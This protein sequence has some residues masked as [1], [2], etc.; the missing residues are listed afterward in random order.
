MVH[1][2]IEPGPHHLGL[3]RVNIR[4]G[5]KGPQGEDILGL[6]EQFV[7]LLPEL[8]LLLHA[9]LVGRVPAA[10]LFQALYAPLQAVVFVHQ[11]LILPGL[12]VLAAAAGVGGELLGGHGLSAVGHIGDDLGQEQAVVRAVGLVHQFQRPV[13]SGIPVLAAHRLVD[14]HLQALGRTG[15]IPV[16]FQTSGTGAGLQ[17]IV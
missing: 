12:G 3:Q 8:L 5:V 7:G 11:G 4:N 10:L 16:F 17:F 13:Q 2:E 1:G 14:L 9:R 15:H 6:D